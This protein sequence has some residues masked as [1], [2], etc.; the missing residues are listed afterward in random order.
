MFK[1][2]R[3]EEFGREAEERWGGTD[4]WKESKR[5]VASYD[6]DDWKVMAVEAKALNDA[7]LARM[8]AGDAAT[9]PEVVALAEEHRQHISKWFYDCSPEIHVGLA[10]MYIADPRFRK[11]Y[12]DQAPGFAQYIAD[13]IRGNAEMRAA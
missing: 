1:G 10:E 2:L 3:N 5:R 7:L 13:A 9:A 4:A 12:D 6:L 8:Q 11:N